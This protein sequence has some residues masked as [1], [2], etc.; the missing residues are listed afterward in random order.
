MLRSYRIPPFFSP[1]SSPP[2]YVPYQL[3]HRNTISVYPLLTSA[4][5]S[6]LDVTIMCDLIPVG[7]AINSC[8]KN[9]L[10]IDYIGYSCYEL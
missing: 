7:V 10:V 9:R 6:I 3:V 4:S 8:A 1:L 2:T 5:S